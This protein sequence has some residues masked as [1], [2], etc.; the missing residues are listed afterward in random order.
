MSA[1][2]LLIQAAIVG[3]VLGA[4]VPLI[5]VFRDETPEFV[6]TSDYLV[7]LTLYILGG[8]ALGALLA[9][10]VVGACWLIYK[11]VAR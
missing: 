3:A 4:A 11:R 5:N 10:V 9:T 7:S 2:R 6:Y 1:V 8:T